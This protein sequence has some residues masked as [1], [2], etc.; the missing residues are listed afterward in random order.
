MSNPL[1]LIYSNSNHR[2][3]G[4][5]V[6]N[7]KLGLEKNNISYGDY[8]LIKDPNEYDVGMLQPINDWNILSTNTIAG[9]NLFVIPSENK[10]LCKH[11]NKF[12]VPSQWVLNLYRQFSELDHSNIYI[13]PVGIDTDKWQ[14]VERQTEHLRCLLY[15]K[16]RSQ[17]DLLVVKKVLNKYNVEYKELH[18]GN[19]HEN[20]LINHCKWANFGILLTDT[21]SQ[22]I[23]YMEMLSTNL[24]LFVFN[25][26]TWDYGG[27]YKTVEATSVPYFDESCGLVS[28]NIDLLKFEEFL[29]GIKKTKYSPGHFIRKNYTLEKC[30]KE[31]YSLFNI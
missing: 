20:D 6:Q 24:P 29:N 31:Y 5:V 11:F 2:G 23:A 4:K 21:E 27:K 19:Y 12:L 30:S 7:L 8:T 28:D 14:M 9:P 25:K 15:Y 3:P 26:P 13:W 10:N 1:V 17:Q 22:G 18:Y 16:N